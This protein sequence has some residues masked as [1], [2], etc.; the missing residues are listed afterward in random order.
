[1]RSQAVLVVEDEAAVALELDR[2]LQ[3]FG[4]RVLGPALTVQQALEMIA[5]EPPDAALL[6]VQ[7]GGELVTPVAEA[8]RA[9][10]VPF[11]LVTAFPDALE[12]AL[13]SVPM[14]LKPISDGDEIRLLLESVLLPN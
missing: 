10:N 8:P 4:Y 2:L 14:V 9:R 12:P 6:D 11:G 1:M 13:R 7:L 5:A 3:G